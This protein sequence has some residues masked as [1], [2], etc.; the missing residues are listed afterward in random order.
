M[1]KRILIIAL[2]G[3]AS[4]PAPA[5]NL[6]EQRLTGRQ[7]NSFGECNSTLASTTARVRQDVRRG[8]DTEANLQRFEQATCTEDGTGKFVIKFPS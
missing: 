4:M 6:S 2:A 8:S 7:F 3:A 5:Q 1:K